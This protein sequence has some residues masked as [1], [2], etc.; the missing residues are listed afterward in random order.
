MIK[1]GVPGVPRAAVVNTTNRVARS[2]GMDCLAA[3]RTRNLRSERGQA[4]E[5]CKEGSLPCV[6][7][8]SGGL[9]TVCGIP[10][11]VEASP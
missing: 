11:S 3:L 2:T 7:V 9:L 4:S 6:V 8:A 1:S 5:A 10:W